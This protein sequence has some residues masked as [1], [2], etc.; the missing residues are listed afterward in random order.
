MKRIA[1]LAITVLLT[2]W[3]TP[4]E[5]ITQR[6]SPA[7]A[8]TYVVRKGDSLYTIA[9]RHGLS[10]EELKR[11]NGLKGTA[12][13]PGQTLALARGGSGKTEG[14][15]KASSKSSPARV[16]IVK[17]GETLSS[18]ARRAGLSV[19]DLKRLNGLK[20][21]A[22]KPG[23]S[24]VLSR[25]KTELPD[26]VAAETPDP[27][28]VLRREAA[29]D[30]EMLADESL[31]PLGEAAFGYLSTP[32]RFGG[33][34]RRGIDCSSFVQQ[35]FRKLDVK[36][37]RSAR[38]QYWMGNEVPR[39][40][41]QRGDLL[42]FR[43]YARFPSHVGIYL[44]DGKMIHASSRSR[45]V[46][47]TE[48]DTPYYRKRY[49]GA[50]R[51]ASLDLGTGLEKL[52]DGVEVTNE[53]DLAEEDAPEEGGQEAPEASPVPAEPPVP[54]SAPALSAATAAIPAN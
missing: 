33:S 39:A 46:V 42:F 19:K 21:D 48:I 51:V 3:T 49:I 29:R 24:L 41:L 17:K 52:A 34:G 38:E 28:E 26:A 53:E 25:P 47:V 54:S 43:T 4:A 14:S 36:L 15:D 45:R 30:P 50:K 10:V 35:V 18:I 1:F 44:G 32:Y 40:E 6:H 31:D 2:A 8:A 7:A 22:L 16:H 11:L 27:G 20:K 9:R 37:P 23:Q 5:A 12:L 13:K